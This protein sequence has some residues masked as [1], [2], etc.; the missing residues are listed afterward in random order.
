M[1]CPAGV[2]LQNYG[3]YTLTHTEIYDVEKEK[4]STG[5]QFPQTPLFR[6]AILTFIRNQYAIVNSV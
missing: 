6:M 2:Q 5:V 1:L 4:T 3:D